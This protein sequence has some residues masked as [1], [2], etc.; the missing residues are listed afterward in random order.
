MI[1]VA[2]LPAVRAQLDQDIEALKGRHPE[3]AQLLANAT[4]PQYVRAPVA[5]GSLAADARPAAKQ[6]SAR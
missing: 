5:S 1:D 2:D 4:A 3:R 6:G